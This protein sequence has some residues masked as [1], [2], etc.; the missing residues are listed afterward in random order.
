MTSLISSPLSACLVVLG[1]WGLIG[2]AGLLRPKSIRIV[3][4]TLFPV[5]A[6]CGVALAVFAA[7]SLGSP[8]ERAVLVIGLPDLPMHVRLDALTAFFLVLLGGASAGIS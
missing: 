5:G 8:P 1:L 4:R 3:G 7:L 6:L 2:L